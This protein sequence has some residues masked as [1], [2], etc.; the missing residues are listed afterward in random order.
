MAAVLG[1]MRGH[2]GA[3]KVYSEPGRGTTF[4][5]LFP[6]VE[7][8]AEQIDRADANGEQWRG[9]GV[10]LLVDDEESVRVVGQ[11]MLERLGYGVLTAADGREALSVYQDNREAVRC[12]VLDLTMPHM[13]GQETFRELRRIDS[14]VCVIMSSG[15]NEQ[16]IR[17]RF[18]GKS[19]SGFV[20]KPYRMHTLA[21]AL[22]EASGECE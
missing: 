12:V 20:Q 6:A 17:E 8:A 21:E 15:Y 22:R 11:R 4:K 5:A 16:E 2:D 10:V 3:I 14:D 9:E 18:A 7:S 13:D 19:L 1:I